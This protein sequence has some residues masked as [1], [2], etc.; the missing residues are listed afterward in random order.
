MVHKNDA[1]RAVGLLKQYQ[2]SLTSPEEQALKTNVGIVSTIF[3]SSLFQALLDIQECYQVTLQL[4]AAQSKGKD[5]CALGAGENSGD[6]E[7]VLRVRV[8]SRKNTQKVE[9]VSGL[10]SHS[11]IDTPKVSHPGLT[12]G[13]MNPL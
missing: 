12:S 2:D 10:V 1:E 3:S 13:L 9:H 7:G 8:T 11:H 4:N 6:E 5:D